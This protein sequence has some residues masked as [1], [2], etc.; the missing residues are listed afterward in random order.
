MSRLPTTRDCPECRP[1][2]P[3][4]EGVSVFQWLGPAPTRQEW[5]R[6]SRRE[7]NFDEEEDKYHHPALMD[8][9]ALRSAGFSGC[10]A[11]KKPKPSTSSH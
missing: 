11:W 1:V 9:V 4:A 5:V 6:S 2:K 3:D 10:E 7:E 8:S